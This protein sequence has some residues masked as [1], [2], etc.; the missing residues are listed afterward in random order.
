MRKRNL[1]S[2]RRAIGSETVSVGREGKSGRNSDRNKYSE[3]L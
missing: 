2:P 3:L 1:I